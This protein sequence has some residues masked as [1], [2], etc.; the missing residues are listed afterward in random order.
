MLCYKS[1]VRNLRS[2]E[3]CGTSP[4]KYGCGIHH[5]TPSSRLFASIPKRLAFSLKEIV[6]EHILLEEAHVFLGFSSDGIYVISY[7]ESFEYMDQIRFPS[8]VFRYHLH[9]WLFRFNQK[10]I[11]VYTVQL[12]SNEEILTRQQLYYAEWPEDKTKILVYGC[13]K[14]SDVCYVTVSAV[15]SQTHCEACC[16]IVPCQGEEYRKCLK[17]GF[18]AHM[19]YN[20][21]SSS[22]TVLNASGLQIDDLIVLNMGYSIGVISLGILPP[23]QDV[24][25]LPLSSIKR[26]TF[27]EKPSVSDAEEFL[28][29]F[30]FDRLIDSG[31]LSSP[32]LAKSN[33]DVLL[34]PSIEADR[35]ATNFK[36]NSFLISSDNQTSN[37]S[38]TSAATELS[39]WNS[40]SLHTHNEL[41]QPISYSNLNEMSEH[42]NCND[43]YSAAFGPDDKAKVEGKIDPYIDPEPKSIVLLQRDCE[44]TY[45]SHLETEF[46]IKSN[47]SNNLV[48]NKLVTS[49]V[50]SENCCCGYT[51]NGRC[52]E[53]NIPDD[54]PN[55]D[56]K[57]KLKSDLKNNKSNKL[58]LSSEFAKQSL[59]TKQNSPKVV[60]V[61]VCGYCGLKVREPKSNQ[62]RKETHSL[63]NS[64]ITASGRNLLMGSPG[65]SS[66]KSLFFSSIRNPR[67]QDSNSVELNAPTPSPS[68]SESSGSVYCTG[69]TT[70]QA[71]AKSGNYRKSDGILSFYETLYETPSDPSLQNGED[72]VIESSLFYGPVNF[73]CANGRPLQPIKSESSRSLMAFSQHL[74]LDI[75]HVIFDVLRTRCYTT[76]KFGYLIDYDVQ[77]VDTCPNTRSVVVLIVALLNIVPR[78]TKT[79]L[80]E[81][82]YRLNG[83]FDATTK[84]QQFHFFICWQLQTGRY[85]VVA[86]SPLQAFDRKKSGKWDASW[87]LEKRR[88][89][90]KACAIPLLSQRSVYV[91]SNS[92]VIRG[93][94]LDYLWDVDRVI[95]L[96]K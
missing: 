27:E 77:I 14:G 22:A 57:D 37:I 51:A 15:P 50:S 46:A 75:E 87:V 82:H 7:T 31:L 78:K 89:I 42:C 52:T 64:P 20:S 2:R 76:Y 8:Y 5:R 84:S 49:D 83:N 58:K 90:Q 43:K 85:E 95:A 53:H 60:N 23:S 29:P 65:R 3:T 68:A 44:N 36:S 96:K 47:G 81:H 70:S 32:R 71:S 40:L 69:D 93:K 6:D 61:T 91:L 66:S 54:T 12:F 86:A 62:K 24:E 45:T 72:N 88:A 67:D 79:K 17:H 74:V 18:V 10:M 25:S 59:K 41:S 73:E 9:W 21:I 19:T 80:Q 94:S 11:K 13:C 56:G 63:S 16:D 28:S 4:A 26:A 92:S 38:A 33:R 30:L 35:N 55:I 39:D 48:S 34:S 1:V